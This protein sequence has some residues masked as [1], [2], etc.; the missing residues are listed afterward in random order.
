MKKLT[1]RAESLKDELIRH[2]RY[3]HQ[4]AETGFD[5]P[6]TKEYITACLK[7]MGY[8]PVECGRAGIKAEAGKGEKTVLLRADTDAL[9][10]REETSLPYAAPENMHACGHDMHTA[11]LLGA[12]K[13][14]KEREKD[15]KNRVVFMFQPAEETLEGAVDMI[16]NGVLDGVDEAVMLHVITAMDMPAGT[17]IVG[18]PGAGAPACDHFTVEIQGKACHGSAPWKG[19]DSLLIASQTVNALQVLQSREVDARKETTLTIG[20][21]QS[22]QNGNT[23]A[24]TAVLK[25]T[26]RSYDEKTREYLRDRITEISCAVAETYKGRAKT[27]FTSG[28]PV[29]VNEKELS[30][31]AFDSLKELLGEE[32]V[33]TT[34]MIS[35]DGRVAR[36][37]G[38]EDF[39]YVSSEVPALMISVTAGEKEKGYIYPQHHPKAEFD[40]GVL[41]VGAAVYA[42]LGMR[43]PPYKTCGFAGNPENDK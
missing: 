35:P 39:A 30:C 23:L 41:P 16:K 2:R 25:G 21:M 5:I 38:S 17:V 18:S 1:E 15:L 14:L 9:P 29:F 27:V 20:Y 43:N 34:S 7:E 4:N 42:Q 33:F 12:A 22:G 8:N 19:V 28:T 26:A 31:R 10:I 40:E 32:R 36:G 13:I 11:M 37:G 3:I 24:D 6:K